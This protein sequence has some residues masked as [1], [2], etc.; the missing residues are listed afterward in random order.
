MARAPCPGSA[1]GIVSKKITDT[2]RLNFIQ[3]MV[4]EKG[5]ASF[6][7]NPLSASKPEDFN[8]RDVID[9][10]MAKEKTHTTPITCKHC[11]SVNM[12]QKK[13]KKTDVWFCSTCYRRIG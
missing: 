13:V 11:K 4:I 10:A 1:G 7:R 6:E 2:M 3:A 5:G 8:V 9:D 12:F